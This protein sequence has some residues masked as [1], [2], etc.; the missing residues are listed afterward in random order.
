MKKWIVLA[1][2][3]S[4]LFV[5]PVFAKSER[6]VEKDFGYTQ[7]QWSKLVRN[8]VLLGKVEEGPIFERKTHYTS[9]YGPNKYVWYMFNITK[10]VNDPWAGVVVSFARIQ[11]K[12]GPPDKNGEVNKV[13]DWRRNVAFIDLD[14]DGFPDRVVRTLWYVNEDT[15]KLKIEYE[16]MREIHPSDREY[17]LWGETVKV[18]IKKKFNYYQEK[19]DEKQTRKSFEMDG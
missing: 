14:I 19:R 11:Y 6:S 18:L 2:I 1:A 8:L 9:G 17:K 15:G 3:L 16:N 7:A 12:D 5:S 13:T 10:R 4:L